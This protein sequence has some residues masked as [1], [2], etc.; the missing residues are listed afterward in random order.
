MNLQEEQVEMLRKALFPA[1][2]VLACVVIAAIVGVQF[3]TRSDRALT[4]RTAL[5][6]DRVYPLSGH[7]PAEEGTHRLEA[8]A[9]LPAP[10]PRFEDREAIEAVPD[11]RPPPG[12]AAEQEPE[13]ASEID[14]LR[15]QILRVA[16]EYP[17]S[18]R[19]LVLVRRLASISPAE[20]L[21][22]VAQLPDDDVRARAVSTIA[23]DWVAKDAAGAI[24][25]CAGFRD[26]TIGR[27]FHRDVV[28]QLVRTKPARALSLVTSLAS[29]DDSLELLGE[30]FRKWAASDPR[31]ATA[32]ALELEAG[33]ERNQLLAG[34]LTIWAQQQL[35][36]AVRAV[37][38][39]PEDERRAAL[40]GVVRRLFL[41]RPGDATTSAAF[42][43]ALMLRA[44]ETENDRERY[45]LAAAALDVVGE[46]D[47]SAVPPFLD[48]LPPGYD[49]KLLLI[50][51]VTE[52]ANVEPLRAAAYA[53]RCATGAD[54]VAAIRVAA[55]GMARKDEA[56]AL[57]WLEGISNPD[58]RSAAT[59]AV[60][61]GMRDLTLAERW[62]QTR[63]GKVDADAA[64]QAFVLRVARDDPP[65]AASW[66]RQILDPA[67]RYF[68]IEAV[69]RAWL[70]TNRP[71]L[72][73]WLARTD[74]PEPRVTRL[75][76][77]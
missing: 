25:A 49:R 18:S 76:A 30:V 43:R 24:A 38:V 53:T 5:L 31:M 75:L 52:A 64:I 55:S 74:L 60:F 4:M 7:M 70:R 29:R 73:A 33:A 67:L 36:D 22:C 48:A 34:A 6:D 37:I 65:L 20:S 23:I 44:N 35:N 19:V 12:I 39:L 46:M 50:R 1:L 9:L 16:M 45:E 26:A 32:R 13:P 57:R 14:R 69:A 58:D 54:R 3:L 47:A 51:L 59:Q 27:E 42:V 63:M 77:R 40:A 2:L 8:A 56:A 72:E 62:L 66:A 68:A 41:S 15:G 21:A 71:A 11:D 28:E 17:G 10:E 61:F